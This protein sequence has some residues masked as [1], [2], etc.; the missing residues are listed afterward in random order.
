MH[1]SKFSYYSDFVVYPIVIAALGAVGI[2]AQSWPTRSEWFAAAV[3]G[4]VLWTLLEYV[5]HRIA[6]HR[7]ACFMPL[8]D[9]HHASPLSLVGTPTWMSVAVLSG[10]IFLP[11]WRC[12]GAHVATGLTAGVMTGYWWYGIVHHTIHH[13]AHKPPHSY[14]GG[15]RA[16]HLRHHYSPKSGNFGVTTAFWDHVFGTAIRI[17]GKLADSR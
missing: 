6:L 2:S 14:F 13:G 16:W 12:F 3:T 1:L 7:I 4:F 9:A 8:H 5:L 10:A 11:A 15:L 17:Q